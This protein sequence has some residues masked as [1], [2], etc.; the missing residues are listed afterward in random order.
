MG[1]HSAPDDEGSDVAVAEVETTLDLSP[2]PRGRHAASD[3]NDLA[4]EVAAEQRPTQMIAVVDAELVEAVETHDTYSTDE[5][6]AP[7]DEAA[8]VAPSKAEQRA[9]RTA[10]R[11]QRKAEK[12]AARGESDSAA[13]LRMLRQHP[14]VR[15]QCLA[16]AMLAFG[17]YWLVMALLGRTGSFVLWL[18]V[19]IVL[20]GVLIGLVLDLAHRR[21]RR[22]AQVPPPTA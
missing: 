16:V 22:R 12:K 13:D 17:L 10:Q 4:A 8:P 5:L 21:E 2:P 7:P 14:M 19:P 18:W 9:A 3:D 11:K 20:S 6:P 1:R 15:V